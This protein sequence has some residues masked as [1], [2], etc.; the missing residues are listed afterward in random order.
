[1]KKSFIFLYFVS[2]VFCFS[3]ESFGKKSDPKT[4]DREAE[5]SFVKIKNEKLIYCWKIKNSENIIYLDTPSSRSLV[6]LKP[7]VGYRSIQSVW[8]QI[9]VINIKYEFSSIYIQKYPGSDPEN[10]ATTLSINE[11][12]DLE[13]LAKKSGYTLTCSADYLAEAFLLE[14]LKSVNES[15]FTSRLSKPP[16]AKMDLN[17]AFKQII[18]WDH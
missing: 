7:K 6:L 1:M 11:I 2:S 16:T 13:L 10:D 3:E 15:S 14:S 17:D 8:D 12:T 18:R 5:F 4:I 9:I